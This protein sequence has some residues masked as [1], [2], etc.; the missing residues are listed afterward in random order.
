M[1]RVAGGVGHARVGDHGQWTL[2]QKMDY[3]KSG[4]G[5][6]EVDFVSAHEKI[7]RPVSY[8]FLWS[9][10]SVLARARLRGNQH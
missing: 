3:F 7:L 1:G 8:R 9:L 6:R 10:N 4:F 5:G 2:S